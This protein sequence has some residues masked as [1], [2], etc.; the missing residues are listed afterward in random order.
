MNL[1]NVISCGADGPTENK[2]EVETLDTASNLEPEETARASDL[3][4]I[5]SQ[6]EASEVTQTSSDC[7][8]S[9]G[10]VD[11]LVS[12]TPEATLPFMP[13]EMLHNQVAN[14]GTWTDE[15]HIFVECVPLEYMASLGDSG[16]APPVMEIIIDDS[17]TALLV[18]VAEETNQN[19]A[20]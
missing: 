3:P 1:N 14:E 6:G 15:G 20:R 4:G 2:T 13:D 7:R 8:Q 12:S 11:P 17:G 9:Q 18:E 5:P 10:S 19:T 16:H